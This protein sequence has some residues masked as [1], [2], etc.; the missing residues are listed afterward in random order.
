M[1]G[2]VATLGGTFVG[3]CLF[4]GTDLGGAH[5]RDPSTS[6]RMTEWLRSGCRNGRAQLEGRLCEERTNGEVFVDAHDGF[7]EQGGDRNDLEAVA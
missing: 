1:R 4:Q 6:L 5:E 2:A 3:N 7:G